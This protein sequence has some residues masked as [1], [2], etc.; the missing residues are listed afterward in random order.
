MQIPENSISIVFIFSF[1]HNNMYSILVI[2]RLFNRRCDDW[3][4]KRVHC[5][6][7][8]YVILNMEWI[9]PNKYWSNQQVVLKNI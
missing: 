7:Y 8:N 6:S 2:C 1:D 4:Y 9:T 5:H 3:L